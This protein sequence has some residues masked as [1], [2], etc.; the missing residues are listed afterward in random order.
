MTT[1]KNPFV[2]G[3]S[4]VSEKRLLREWRDVE[5]PACGRQDKVR[6]AGKV[7]DFRLNYVSPVR[8]GSWMLD[9]QIWK[10][11]SGR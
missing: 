2:V 10:E 11:N 7:H 6:I 1:E 8:V 3:K 9:S 5:Q 4:A